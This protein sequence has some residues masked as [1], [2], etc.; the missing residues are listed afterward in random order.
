MEHWNCSE[1]EFNIK[2]SHIAKKNNVYYRGG[3]ISKVKVESTIS[4]GPPT[5]E[6]FLS[7]QLDSI[8]DK[9]SDLYRCA[10]TYILSEIFK[11]CLLI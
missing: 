9:S 7:D 10:T 6:I 5:F 11:G 2:C 3:V 4:D 8:S 1:L